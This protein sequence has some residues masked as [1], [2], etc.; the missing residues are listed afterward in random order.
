MFLR[1]RK[2]VRAGTL[3]VYSMA[4]LASKGLDKLSGVLLPTVP[5]R[6]A[7]ALDAMGATA[8]SD[9]T[10]EGAGAGAARA[11]RQPGAVIL[12]GERLA[13]VPG[14]LSAVV[15][16]GR[17]RPGPAWPGSRGAPASAAPSR[18]ARCPACCRAAAPSPTRPPGPRWPGPGA[19]ARCRPRPAATPAEIL[20]AAATGQLSALLVAGVDPADLP[21]PAAALAALEAA[22][23]VVSLELRVSAVTDRA[24]VVFPVAAVAEKAG[25][26]VNW[27]GRPGTFG[28]ALPVPAVRS[29][30]QVLAAAGRRDG[31]A[32][33][34]ARRRRG[35][36][37]VQRRCAAARPPTTASPAAWATSGGRHAASSAGAGQALLAT[38]HNLLDGGRMQDGEPNLA[39]TARPTVARMSA[40]TAAE[41]ERGRDGKV[42]VATGRGTVT[43]PVEIADMPDRVVWLP[44]NSAGCGRPARAR[45]RA[46]HPSHVEERGM[47]V[48]AASAARRPPATARRWPASGIDPWWLILLKVIVIFVFLLVATLLTIWAERRVIG[49]MQQ[50]P[51]PNRAGKFGLLQSL[52]D[53]IKLALMEDIIPRGV[54]K[55]LFV[56]APAVAAIPAF[57]SLAI[58]PFGPDG[59]DLRPP[60]PAAAHR[61]AG[62][63]AAG[64]G[65]EL[66]GASTGSCWPGGRRPRPTRCSAALRSSAQVISYEIAMG[67]SFVPV[68]LY[69]GSLSTSQIVAGPGQRRR[70][71]PV[72]R[73]SCT[74]RPGSRSCCC[75]RS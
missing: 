4:A 59:L 56:I 25:T 48:L 31:R 45:R 18:R 42:T 8:D 74:T 51:G 54:D 29:D 1:L 16:A 2:A 49:R 10:M 57:I 3:T 43:V 32:P 63:R 15:A 71:P 7:A 6:E 36:P 40:A 9:D 50:R 35:P 61:P 64:A 62:G 20:A 55:L 41:A 73:P 14:A 34:P 70:V 30:L 65:H 46:R 72:R 28:P 23:F 52:M 39:G 33:G 67:L 12:A 38:W 47:T 37:R 68:F 53:G 22:S 26:F 21:D 13:E 27:E 60:H 19:S 44:A 5:G 66:D 17:A 11:L 58:I 24:D 75:R 69:A